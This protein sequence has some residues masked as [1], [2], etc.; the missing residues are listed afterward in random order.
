[1]LRMLTRLIAI[2]LLIPALFNFLLFLTDVSEDFIKI[3]SG[4]SLG[5]HISQQST[6]KGISISEVWIGSVNYLNL[7]QMFAF[8][9]ISFFFIAI[10]ESK[11]ND[12]SFLERARLARESISSFLAF[13]F[14]LFIIFLIIVGLGLALPLVAAFPAIMVVSLINL[15]W[16]LAFHFA[17]PAM[18]I[19]M[20]REVVVLSS[21]A[22]VLSIL[23]SRVI[24]TKE[25]TIEGAKEFISKIMDLTSMSAADKY[26]AIGAF[27]IYFLTIPLALFHSYVVVESVGEINLFSISTPISVGVGYLLGRFL[28]SKIAE[29]P[30]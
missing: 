7:F 19:V 20:N 3:L 5:V 23:I 28:L 8:L 6:E 18:L 17:G 16:T 21:A 30:T 12:R 27:I 10:W 15:L 22:T 26:V 25:Q 1:M 9:S 2:L 24:A 13:I 29:F 11:I 4:E 14:W